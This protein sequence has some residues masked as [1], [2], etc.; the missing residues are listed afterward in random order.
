MS[1]DKSNKEQIKWEEHGG[2]SPGKGE[3]RNQETG[4]LQSKP[5]K[6]PKPPKKK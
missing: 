5:A 2:A 1:D 4:S 6:A 3:F